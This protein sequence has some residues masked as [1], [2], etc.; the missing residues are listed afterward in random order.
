MSRSIFVANTA[1]TLTNFRK[2]LIENLAK[3]GEPVR[4]MVPENCRIHKTSAWHSLF[5]K[6]SNVEFVFYKQI[7]V[8]SN[9]PLII[10]LNILLLQY[11]LFWNIQ[12]RDK[13]IS[14]T[15][16]PNVCN[17]VCKLVFRKRIRSFINITGLG[18]YFIAGKKNIFKALIYRAIFLLYDTS[19][20]IFVQNKDDHQIVSEQCSKA[21]I[22]LIPGSGINLSKFY[23]NKNNST[24]CTNLKFMFAGRLIRDKGVYDLIQADKILRKRNQEDYSVNLFGEIDV[25]NYGETDE[26]TIR[27]F[28]SLAHVFHHGHSDNMGHHYNTNDVLI[29]PSYREGLPKVCLEAMAC[30]LALI[31]YNVAG[32]RELVVHEKN[33]LKVKPHSPQA[34]SDAMLWCLKNR[35]RL[36]KMG[37]NGREIIK[38]RYDVEKVN[39]LICEILK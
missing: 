27:E 8:S 13:V 30:G 33:G 32:S 26:A 5:D 15:I 3:S 31:V 16:I 36:H 7:N 11:H 4:L 24:Q 28:T 20:N 1:F 21:T 25:G 10:L 39:K 12:T 6:W 35:N 18:S 23:P 29:L 19:N 17:C 14:Y 2:E 34:L 37:E 9:N 22:N 38:K